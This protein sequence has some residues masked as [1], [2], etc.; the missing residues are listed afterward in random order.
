[1]SENLILPHINTYNNMPRR[2]KVEMYIE[3]LDIIS[4]GETKPTRIM[5][6][7]NLSWKVF[8][9]VLGNLVSQSLVMESDDGEGGDVKRYRVTDSGVSVLTYFRKAAVGLPKN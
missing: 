1:L 9:K 3:V 8:Q 4:K 7:A 5:Y 2:G 6:S